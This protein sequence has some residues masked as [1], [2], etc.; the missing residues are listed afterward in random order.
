MRRFVAW[1]AVVVV[2]SL[3]VV[4]STW[5]SPIGQT[6]AL[7]D[8]VQWLQSFW[9]VAVTIFEKAANLMD[10]NGLDRSLERL[11][12]AQTLTRG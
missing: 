4:P 10:P 6:V 2:L 8:W 9:G 11:E 5:A 12:P 3:A 7:G 1:M